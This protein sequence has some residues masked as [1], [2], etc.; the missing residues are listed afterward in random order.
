MA[1]LQQQASLP[2][3]LHLH[4]HSRSAHSSLPHLQKPSD[5]TISAFPLTEFTI[6]GRRSR[7][8]RTL[9]PFP[10]LALAP[11][12]ACFSRAGLRNVAAFLE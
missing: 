12:D 5:S 6:P 10:H 4:D 11:T 2:P 8:E 3:I 1:I 9:L 7:H